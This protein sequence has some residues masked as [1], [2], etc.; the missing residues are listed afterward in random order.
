MSELSIEP[1]GY[2]IIVEPDSGERQSE[3]GIVIPETS[4]MEQDTGTLV[5]VG[6][7]AWRDHGDGTPWAQVGDR[8]M[9][10]KYGGKFVTDPET[11][12]EY[13]V[14]NDEDLNAVIRNGVQSDS[15][16]DQ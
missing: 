1:C 8:V 11:H 3:G 9:F 15:R 4:R 5:A 14:L 12:K 2:R 13:K 10:A 6:P 16:S 7:L